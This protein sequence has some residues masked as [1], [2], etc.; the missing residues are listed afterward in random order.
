M[1]IHEFENHPAATNSVSSSGKSIK[2]KTS[3]K[4]KRRR[5]TPNGSVKQRNLM[6]SASAGSVAS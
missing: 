2:K 1:H 5:K 6:A 3:S 4:S